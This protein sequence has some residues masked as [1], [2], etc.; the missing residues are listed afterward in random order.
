MTK[1]LRD[2][3]HKFTDGDLNEGRAVVVMSQ[4]PLQAVRLLEK[5]RMERE[6]N[7]EFTQRKEKIIEKARELEE[8]RTKTK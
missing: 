2:H 3:K 6:I 1:K 5:E 4:R 7:D 8:V